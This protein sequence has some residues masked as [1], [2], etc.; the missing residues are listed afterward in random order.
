[1]KPVNWEKSNSLSSEIQK[2]SPF[3][4]GGI[5]GFYEVSITSN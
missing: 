1:M 5:W 3:I 4:S 2:T